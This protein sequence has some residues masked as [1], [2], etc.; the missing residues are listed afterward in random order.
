MTR[1]EQTGRSTPRALVSNRRCRSSRSP[2]PISC[3]RVPFCRASQQIRN[4]ATVGGNLLQR[5][6]CPYYYDTAFACNKREP[7]TGCAALQV[8]TGYALFGASDQCVAVH[9]RYVRSSGSAGCDRRSGRTKGKRQMPFTDFH[10]LP[11][12]TPQRD[13]N[14]KPGELIQSSSTPAPFA[15][16]VY[17]KL[18]DRASYAFCAGFGGGGGQTSAS[19][20]HDWQ[21][22]GS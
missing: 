12:N 13:T 3:S 19:K 15:K 11:G 21:W 9:L 8:L 17:L 18:R 4:V 22:A 5:T 14:L 7:D 6:R 10:R 1:I 16:P 20:Q 2:A